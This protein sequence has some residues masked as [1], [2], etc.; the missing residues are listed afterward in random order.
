MKKNNIPLKHFIQSFKIEI[1]SEIKFTD[2]NYVLEK[3]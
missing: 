2:E 1:K 3:C